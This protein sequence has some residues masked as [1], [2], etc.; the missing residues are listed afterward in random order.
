MIIKALAIVGLATAA[1]AVA[2][3]II[4]D[5]GSIGESYTIT[6]DGFVDGGPSIDGLSSELTLTLTGIENGV[7]TFSYSMTNTGADGDGIGSRVS[8]FAFNTDPDIDS[9]TSTGTYGFTNTS[10]NYPNGIGTVD[11]CFSGQRTGS[12]AGG[13]SGGVFDGSTG[14][15]TLSLSFGTA[16]A[17]LTLNDFFVRYQSITGVDGVGS[18]SGRQTSS[19]STSGGTSSGTDVPEPGMMLLFALAVLGLALGTRRRRFADV[20]PARLAYA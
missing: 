3:P 12:C 7:Y 17:T 2:E 8:G 10:S 4:L 15:G 19:S 16:P 20:M 1:P 14:T 5:A 18:A 6:F 11:V 9:A 13:G